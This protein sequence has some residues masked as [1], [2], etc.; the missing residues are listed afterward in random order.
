[1][2]DQLYTFFA[3]NSGHYKSYQIGPGS[4][5]DTHGIALGK[6][7]YNNN[8]ETIKIGYNTERTSPSLS[9]GPNQKSAICLESAQETFN[10]TDDVDNIITSFSKT[11][12]IHHITGVFIYGLPSGDPNVSGAIYHDENGFIKYSSPD[13]V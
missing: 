10:I 12:I 3:D 6:S 13:Y 9:L 1:M 5:V 2:G 8:Y 4:Q 7:V 11:G